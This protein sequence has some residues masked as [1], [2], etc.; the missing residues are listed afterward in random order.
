MLDNSYAN[1][2]TAL[3]SYVKPTSLKNARLVVVNQSLAEALDLPQKWQ[4]ESG[5]F[6]ALFASGG[7]LNHSAMAQ[8]YGGHQFGHWNPELGD[9][10]GLLLAEVIDKH[11]NRWDLHL[12]GAGP[13]PYSRFADGRAVLR[14]SIRVYL[15]SE[16]L[17]HLGIPSSRALC[18]ISSDEPVYREKQEKGAMLIRVAQSHVR[19]GHF[20]YFHY[21]KQPEKLQKLFDYCFKHHFKECLQHAFPYQ[22]VFEKIVKDTASLVAKWQAF[23]FNHGVMNTD[24][25]SIHGITFDYGPYAFLDDFEPNF[26]CNHSDPQGRYS[27]DSQPG[28]GLWNLNALAQPFTP[29]LNAEQI[30][31]ALSLYEPSLISEYSA[32]MRGKFGLFASSSK[33]E[34]HSNIINTWL[35]MLAAEKKDYTVCFRLLCEFDMH[36]KNIKLRD[37]FIHRERFDNWAKLYSSALI[38][39]GVEQD[40][41]HKKMAQNNPNIVL[42]NYLAQQVIEQAEKGDFSMFEQFIAALQ[43]PYDDI[44]AYKK[45]SLPPPTWGKE[46][47]ISCSS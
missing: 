14:S 11:Q 46:L 26:I 30:K 34:H 35:D 42:R 27:F 7:K 39:Q 5:L 33:P 44:Y 37:Q 19:F 9:G 43:K 23:G 25:M 24:N 29:Y 10:R 41:R 6:H 15:A 36:G 8:K 22:A 20:E 40:I 17:F 16:A 38:E 32:L 18:L 13:T 2:L 21:S 12:K 45:F 4:T 3:G 1:E 47:Q 28:I 31:Q